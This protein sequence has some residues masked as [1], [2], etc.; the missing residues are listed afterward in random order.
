VAEVVL[1]INELVVLVDQAEVV[2]IL[3]EVLEIHHPLH[4]HRVMME[5]MAIVV[6]EH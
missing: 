5:V 1:T 3:M 2:A 6:V 4:L